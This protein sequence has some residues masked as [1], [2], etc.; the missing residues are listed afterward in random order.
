MLRYS[1]KRTF[2][3]A[4]DLS[5]SEESGGAKVG[6]RA[7]RHHGAVNAKAGHLR[8]L[9]APPDFVI[10][11]SVAPRNLLLAAG[12]EGTAD[13][14]LRFGMTRVFGAEVKTKKA[15]IARIPFE[16]MT[17]GMS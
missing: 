14:S 12:S 8:L 4:A 17:P 16:P 2:Y 7:D 1:L 10:P 9:Q 15:A 13:S 5:D 11:R 3:G 6:V